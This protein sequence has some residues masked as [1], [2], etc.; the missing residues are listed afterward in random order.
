MKVRRVPVAAYGASAPD[1]ALV[2]WAATEG[3]VE[4]GHVFLCSTYS[5]YTAQ[6]DSLHVAPEHRS[7]GVASAL[8]RACVRWARAQPYDT[9][10]LRVQ[11]YGSRH[12]QLNT[13]QLRAFYTELGF[14]QL[15]T[16]F[17]KNMMY[18]HL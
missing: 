1:N 10:V 17:F 9:L 3:G 6:V 16:G 14:S 7:R 2:A 11:R 15:D 18:R 13:A 12:R 8:M 5:T 4:I